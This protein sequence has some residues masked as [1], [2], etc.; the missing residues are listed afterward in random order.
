MDRLEDIEAFLTI[1]D[2]GSLSAAARRLSRSLQSVSR[3]LMT[4]ERSVGVALIHR[5]TRQSS[6]T[7]AG[8]AFYRRVKPAFIEI[9]EARLEAADHHA[10][11][12]G[13]LRISAPVFFSPVYLVPIVAAFMERYPRIEVELKLSDKFFDLIDEDLDLAVRIGDVHD[14]GLKARRLGELRC[15]VF[16][17]TSYFARHGRPQHPEDLARHQCIVRAL[18]RDTDKWP[19]QID[20]KSTTIG[21]SGRFRADTSAAVYAAATHGLGI[22]FTPLWQIR[23]L[24]D[25]RDLELVLCEFEIPRIPI[26]AV[27]PA[28]KL[29]LAKT[30]LFKDFLLRQLK[31]E[32]L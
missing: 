20:G 30:Q 24:V 5:T 27:W 23:E 4:L 25:R 12:S 10:E 8:R 19:F 18:D 28:S 11:P 3:S 7:E 9:S 31:C 17:A 22:G 16:G 29:P 1:I 2:E 32:R 6:P 15:V 14:V 13:V 21:V 26:H